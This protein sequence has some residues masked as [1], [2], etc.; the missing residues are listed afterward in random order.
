MHSLRA[1][2]QRSWLASTYLRC[3]ELLDFLADRPDNGRRTTC[4]RARTWPPHHSPP[5]DNQAMAVPVSLFKRCNIFHSCCKVKSWK[6]VDPTAKKETTNKQ[7]QKTKLFKFY[8]FMFVK[9]KYPRLV[10]NELESGCSNKRGRTLDARVSG[11]EVGRAETDSAGAF[12]AAFGVDSA[13]GIG[14]RIDDRRSRA[15]AASDG[16][17]Y[18][19]WL[20]RALEAAHRVRTNGIVATRVRQAFVDI[21]K[22]K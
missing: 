11:W 17:A 13:S 7:R 9:P 10:A 1:T 12:S 16:V 15:Q 2:N 4:H 22:K 6:S 18:A 5:C 8:I 3:T 19:A 20:A 21:C 14:T